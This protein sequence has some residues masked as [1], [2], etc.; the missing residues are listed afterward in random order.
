MVKNAIGLLVVAVV[1]VHGYFYLSFGTLDPCTAAAFK[2]INQEKSQ[3]ARSAGALFSGALE[4]MIRSKGVAA[5]YRIAITGE[6]PE[7]LI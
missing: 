1:A 4:N 5:C 3:A 2:V 7:N 6:K